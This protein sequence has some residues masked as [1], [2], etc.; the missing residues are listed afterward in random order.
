MPEPSGVGEPSCNRP[1][2]VR[3]PCAARL[4]RGPTPTVAMTR[5]RWM[6]TRAVRERAETRSEDQP[7]GL[8]TAVPRRASSGRRSWRAS[9]AAP[10]RIEWFGKR[11]RGSVSGASVV[12]VRLSRSLTVVPSSTAAAGGPFFGSA[13]GAASMGPDPPSPELPSPEPPPPG[14]P[15]PELP[16]PPPEP[17]PEFPLLEPPPPPGFPP[18]EPPAA[19]IAVAGVA[20]AVATAVAG[21]ASGVAVAVTRIGRLSMVVTGLTGDSCSPGSA[22]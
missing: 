5:L 14:L 16:V 15:L 1:R 18:P 7:W 3:H 17:P 9:L 13:T 2:I 22:G 10:E 21:V 20:S 8:G 19:G 12:L 11:Q 6:R 4:R